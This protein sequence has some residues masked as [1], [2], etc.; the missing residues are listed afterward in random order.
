MHR[1]F[2]E[3]REKFA[4]S[5]YLVQPDDNQYYINTD[6]SVKAIGAVLMQKDKEDRTNIV[7]AGSRVLTVPERK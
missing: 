4:H 3:F 6:A 7:S 5:I 2:E 1:A